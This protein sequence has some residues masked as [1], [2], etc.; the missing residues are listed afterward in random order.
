MPKIWSPVILAQLDPPRSIS[1]E[2]YYH[3]NGRFLSIEDLRVK[4][5]SAEAASHGKHVETAIKVNIL[6]LMQTMD[7]EP[8]L[9]NFNDLL[10]E[11]LKVS[12]FDP[13]ISLSWETAMIVEVGKI[14]CEGELIEQSIKV[15][16][17]ID[18]SVL[19]VQNEA[20]E[21][22]SAE[23]ADL[24]Y[25]PDSYYP[26]WAI[27]ETINKL[28]YEVQRLSQDNSALHHRI[29]LY[30]KNLNTLKN[31]LRKAEGRSQDLITE[32]LQARR[33]RQMLQEKLDK[34]EAQMKPRAVT[35][36]EPAPIRPMPERF[37]FS[38]KIRQ[39][40]ALG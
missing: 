15:K 2:R 20:I 40:F 30:E 35:M 23:E 28:E 16:M 27:M 39:L 4:V 3:L 21:V 7:G 5:Q 1:A 11:W 25:Q 17:H 34:K 13:P 26:G 6:A 10:K 22:L 24:S 18:Y 9:L 36:N 33:S 14:A 32:L 29:M 8:E 38:E 12:C 19:A 31:A 37:H